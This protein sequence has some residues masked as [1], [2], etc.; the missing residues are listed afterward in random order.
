MRAIGF[1]LSNRVGPNEGRTV[2]VR[3]DL[4]PTFGFDESNRL[5]PGASRTVDVALPD[6]LVVEFRAG[7]DGVV[8]ATLFCAFT[9]DEGEASTVLWLMEGLFCEGGFE[10]A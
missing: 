5:E 2:E 10:S 9:G 4:R 3:T 7:R 1:D 6:L 8:G